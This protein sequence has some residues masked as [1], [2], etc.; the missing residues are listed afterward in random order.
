MTETKTSVNFS[1]FHQHQPH[2]PNMTR[3]KRGKQTK[4]KDEKAE[5]KKPTKPVAPKMSSI[6]DLL[7]LL[8]DQ[9][10]NEEIANI[11]NFKAVNREFNQVANRFLETRKLGPFPIC[12]WLDFVIPSLG[13]FELKKLQRVSKLSKILSMSNPRSLFLS[14]SKP[15]SKHLIYLL[16]KKVGIENPDDICP[17]LRLHPIL[18]A[19]L[20]FARNLP[21]LRTNFRNL[22]PKVGSIAAMRENVSDPPAWSLVIKLRVEHFDQ[23][24]HV[25]RV[26]EG[27]GKDGSVTLQDTFVALSQV[28]GNVC[29]F[30]LRL[31]SISS[32]FLSN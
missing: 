8:S 13:Y 1:S 28:L 5:E 7:L 29:E 9:F 4:R 26:V 16:Y 21:H 15:P 20:S 23:P 12:V 3:K 19:K 25:H 24:R 6:M 17:N 22:H 11:L 27:S 10:A 30:L 31:S 2:F 32:R 18:K 14:R